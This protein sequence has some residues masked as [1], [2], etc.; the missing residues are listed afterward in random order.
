MLNVKEGGRENKTHERTHFNLNEY[1]IHDSKFKLNILHANINI[2]MCQQWKYCCFVCQLPLT[3]Y[4]RCMHNIVALQSLQTMLQCRWEDKKYRKTRFKLKMRSCF[5]YFLEWNFCPVINSYFFWAFWVFFFLLT[6][7]HLCTF[8]AF[9]RGPGCRWPFL[10][11]NIFR[12]NSEWTF[13][14]RFFFPVTRLRLNEIWKK[15]KWCTRW[16]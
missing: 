7:C 12:Y 1:L 2:F 10:I 9:F 15:I 14:W 6:L 8:F 5:L 11:C 3:E 13:P 16:N 4:I